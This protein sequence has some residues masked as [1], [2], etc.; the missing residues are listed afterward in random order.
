MNK[1]TVKKWLVIVFLI[2]LT[3][4]AQAVEAEWENI[5]PDDNVTYC[6]DVGKIAYSSKPDPSLNRPKKFGKIVGVSWRRKGYLIDRKGTT[7][8]RDTFYYIIDNASEE[9]F[10]K[11]CDEINPQ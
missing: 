10:L 5:C 8:L 1:R 2:A 7:S 3:S 6:A 4:I 9:T 11:Q